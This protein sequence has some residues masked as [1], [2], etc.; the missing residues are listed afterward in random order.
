MA[1]PKRRLIGNVSGDFYVDDTC[2]DCD[3][4]RWLAPETFFRAHGQSA[5][6]AQPED[7]EARLR[8]L[9]AAVACP[10]ASIGTLAPAPEMPA[11][12]AAFPLLVSEAEAESEE[13]YYCGYHSPKSFGAASY[14]V[15]RPGGNVLVD[16]PRFSP[17][18]AERI[19]SLGGARWM[20]LTHGDDVAD[21][22]AWRDRL[23]CDRVLH[24]GDVTRETRGVER[25]LEGGDAVDL[26]KDLRVVPVPGHTRG[27]CVLLAAERFLFTGDHLAWSPRLGHLYA[28]RDANWF[29]WPEQ[30]RSME[31]LRGYA[32]TWVLPGHGRRYRASPEVMA[33]QLDACLRWMRN[34]GADDGD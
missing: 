30:I 9:R 31:K 15:R 25:I 21:H 4:C 11:V 27:S 20:F 28:F 8:A 22:Q 10:T 29:S 3:T 23:G 19:E 34:A 2:I 16:S 26:A 6:K 17:T 1:N 13:V 12:R 24:A 5:V 33:G 32:F 14:L 7:G 18:L